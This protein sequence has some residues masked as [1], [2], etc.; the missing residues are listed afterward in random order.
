MA[1]ITAAP[2]NTTIP[3]PI[4]AA[5]NIVATTASDISR[6]NGDSGVRNDDDR[7]EHHSHHRGRSPP[8]AGPTPCRSYPKTG[9]KCGEDKSDRE[10]PSQNQNGQQ[11]D[12]NS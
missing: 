8:R 5:T 3:M 10:G 1:S 7:A 11:A 2:T 6:H 12:C 9:P 4:P